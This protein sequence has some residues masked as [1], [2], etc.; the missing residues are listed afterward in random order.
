MSDKPET[1]VWV[2]PN[3]KEITINCLPATVEYAE[4]LGWK[5]E[6]AKKAAPKK[7]AAPKGDEMGEEEKTLRAEY[8]EHV[9]KE[10][11][12]NLGKAKMLE[13]IAEAKKAKADGGS[14]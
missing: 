3:G 7:A 1:A 4:S 10:A 9:G 6:G 12:H 8:L 11:H 5:R 14:D 2:K 13:H